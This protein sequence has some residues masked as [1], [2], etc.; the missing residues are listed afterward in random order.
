ML[1][2]R[3]TCA[4]LLALVGPMAPALHAA[5]PEPPNHRKP[6]SDAELRFWLENMVWHHRFTPAEITAA[7]GLSADDIAAV[8]KKFDIRA[9][10]KPKR[11]GT[12]LL[13]LPYP[14]G[15]HPRIGFLEGAIRPQRETK[16]SVFCPWDETSYVVVDVPEAIWS[17]LGLTY[18][19]H[20]HVPTIWTK[21]NIE[22]PALE[23]SRSADGMLTLERKLPNGIAF[24]AKVWPI[25]DQKIVGMELTL[26]NGTKEKLS[27]LRVQ[28][29]AMLKGAAGFEQQTNDNKVFT[30][31]FAACKSADGKRWII[32]AWEPLHRAWG[33]AKCPCLH[34]DPKFPDTAPGETQ[35]IRGL[36]SFHEGAEIEAEQKRLAK[37]LQELAPPE[38]KTSR[39]RGA[40]L[41]AETGKPIAARVYLQAEDGV[42]L[43][44][45]S[46]DPKGT[47][48]AYRKQRPDVP[49]C[50]EIHTTL[51][52][53]P[54]VTDVPP[55]K[56]TLTVER[57]KEYHTLSQS[58]TVG[59][60]P[61]EVTLQLKRWAD[62][63]ARGWYSGD[64][65]VHRTLEELPNAMLADDLNVALPLL[66]WVTE[67]FTSPAK[68]PKSKEIDPG[69]LIEIDKTHAIYPRNTEYEIFRVGK[70]SHTL[71]AF[72]VLNHQ[73]LFDEGV[74]PVSKIAQR[75]HKEGSLIELDKH[76]WPWSMMLVPVMPVDLFELTNNHVWRTAFGFPNF[77][78]PP[79]DTMKIERDGK[80]FTE[81]GWIDYGFQ[82][83]YTLLNC[84]YRLRPTAGTASGV[85]P[86]PLG[87]GRVYVQLPDGFSYE[88]WMRGL[89][90]GRSFVTTGPLL[91]VQVNGQPPGHTFKQTE[92]VRDYQITGSAQS[93]VPLERIEI[94][95][96]GE[97]VRTLKPENRRTK[98][99]AYQSNI[100]E[101]LKIDGSS[102]LAV[103]CFEDRP[104]QRPRFAHGSP[105]HIDVAGK[106]LRPKKEQ[107][108]FLVKRVED[109]LKRSAE[110]LPKEAL[111]EYRQALRV[112]R[113]IAKTAR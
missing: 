44:V 37:L 47:A 34:S 81:R 32:A 11:P 13:M 100:D 14:G 27:D 5:D 35:R 10:N 46:D 93:A 23:W 91:F 38:K 97:V 4:L 36:L 21:Q 65:H 50:V 89:N 6:N 71:G 73:T 41:D 52:A 31:P 33:N 70:A 64:T 51:S 101:K 107:I 104:D 96:N 109:Q 80:G 90:A 3:H 28:V 54:F 49:G 72:F 63:A 92:A 29:C 58:V 56:Y 18:L 69:R 95:V 53:H 1:A 40:V 12:S 59:S 22:L 87:F 108:D 83:Y 112:Y 98:A 76:N 85:H 7:T 8:L 103:R 99:D 79:A 111:D 74:P 39:L 15:R 20:T 48:V 67:A 105:V 61:V 55:G 26:T 62:L 9:D 86:V 25:A 42:W 94:V 88:N 68:N 66:H 102:W 57:G 30:G 78:E 75:A 16:F 84:G 17:N 106:P 60:E 113:E 43:N 24:S 77:G 82:N 19:A 45:R 110:V 2:L